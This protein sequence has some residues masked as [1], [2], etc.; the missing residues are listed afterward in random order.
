[1]TEPVERRR[2]VRLFLLEFFVGNWSV[3]FRKRKDVQDRRRSR[4]VEHTGVCIGDPVGSRRQVVALGH[5]PFF[6]NPRL[7]AHRFILRCFGQL[8]AMKVFG[9]E[10][11]PGVVFLRGRR[12]WRKGCQIM[13]NVEVGRMSSRLPS[14]LRDDVVKRPLDQSRPRAEKGLDL[15]THPSTQSRP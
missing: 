4:H 15:S 13:G 10:S 14:E 1:L 9:V 3:P 7:P 11:Q 5:I 6:E 12:R 8:A 2:A